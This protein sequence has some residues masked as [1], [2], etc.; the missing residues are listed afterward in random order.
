VVDE[1][2]RRCG[3]AQ[4]EALDQLDEHGRRAPTA[5]VGTRRT[6]Q[7]RQATVAIA[8]QPPP[9]GPGR[10]AGPG[11]RGAQGHTVV[12]VRSHDDEPAQRFLKVLLA[13]RRRATPGV[14]CAASVRIIRSVDQRSLPPP[15]LARKGRPRML[16]E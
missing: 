3:T 7:G 4:G 2:D 6:R 5:T 8:R 15:T 16:R 14:R 13:E 12:Q 1:R 10:H 11:R 9:G